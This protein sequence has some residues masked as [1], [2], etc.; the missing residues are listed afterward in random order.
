MS[1]ENKVDTVQLGDGD[2][3][4]QLPTRPIVLKPSL[5]A[6]QTL[7]RTYGGLQAVVD[8]ISALE[9]DVIMRVIECGLGNRTWN[10]KM[11]EAFAEEVF[12]A[13]L[14]DDSGGIAYKCIDYIQSLM[15]G[16]RPAPPPSDVVDTGEDADPTKP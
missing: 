13:G 9:W 10:P 8:K 15:R 7:S 5:Y 16:G 11:K 12:R 2:V 1:V 4:I 3:T 14:T 6:F